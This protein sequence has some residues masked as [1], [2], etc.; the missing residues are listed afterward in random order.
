M[1]DFSFVFVLGLLVLKISQVGPRQEIARF[2]PMLTRLLVGS[3]DEALH[4]IVV[5]A[6]S[7]SVLRFET[8]KDGEK[9]LSTSF[10][11][12]RRNPCNSKR[13]HEDER[14]EHRGGRSMRSPVY[15]R[16]KRIEEVPGG[17]EIEVAEDDEFPCMSFQTSPKLRV[18]DGREKMV[19]EVLQI[20]SMEHMEFTSFP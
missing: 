9:R 6:N 19:P 2:H 20:F 10:F 17:V 13:C 8:G 15:G 4:K 1:V 3:I 12:P 11:D 7:W 5:G 16:I 14:S 18:V